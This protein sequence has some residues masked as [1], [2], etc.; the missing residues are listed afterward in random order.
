MHAISKHRRG[1]ATAAAVAT[2]A[3]LISLV[4]LGTGTAAAEPSGAA[5]G[6]VTVPAEFSVD[7]DAAK[8]PLAGATGFLQGASGGQTWVSYADGARVPLPDTASTRFGTG[9]DVIAE[10][11]GA[12]IGLRDP[13]SGTA[14]HLTVPVGQQ[15]RTMLGTSVVT[16]EPN[17]PRRW[18]LLTREADK[19][20]DRMMELPAGAVEVRLGNVRSAYGFMLAYKLDGVAEN[21]WVDATMTPRPLRFG[22]TGGATR[23]AGAQMFRGPVAGRMEVWDLAGDFSA[24]SAAL[25]WA[26]GV[27]V[28]LLG[29]HVLARVPGEAGTERL[30]ARALDGGP[31]RVVLDH[32]VGDVAVGPGGRVVATSTAGGS[33]HTYHSVSVPE[34]GGAPVATRV[35]EAPLARTRVKQVAVAQGVM[36]TLDQ[37]PWNRA[38][39]RAV[40]LGVGTDPSAGPRT[41]RGEDGSLHHGSC[42][43]GGD[44]ENAVPTGDGR[45]VFREAGY[46]SGMYVLQPGGTLPATRVSGVDDVGGD[47]GASGR[48]VLYGST[49]EW[50]VVDL[51]TGAL[52]YRRAHGGRG[53]SLVG[54]S[55]WFP[56]GG[57]SVSAVDVRSGT[58][59]RTAKVA[60]CE[61]KGVE[62]WS[63]FAHWRCDTT[64]G[65]R[66]LATGANVALPGVHPRLGDGYAVSTRGADLLLTPLKGSAP[67]RVL[68]TGVD[69][70]WTVDRF[71]GHVSYVD[72]RDRVHVVPAGVPASA[73][74]V[75]DS[76]RPAEVVDRRAEAPRSWSGKWWLSKPAASWRAEFR[77]RAGEVV[78]TL[79]GGE[80]RGRIDAVWDGKAADG[81]TLADGLYGW[82]LTA[83]PADGVGPALTLTGDVALTRERS[84]ASGTYR[85]VTPTRVMD[86]RGG[87]GA[88]KAKV[89]PGGTVTLQVGG[90]GG[91]PASGVS[92]VVMNV[93]ATNATSST[94]VSVYPAG[95]VRTSASNLNVVAG[96]NVSNL[97]TVP[98]VDGKATFY[99][100]AGSVD[101]LADVAGY[102]SLAGDGSRFAPVKPARILDTRAGLGAPKAE[103]GAGRTVNVQVTGRGGVP[104]SGVSAVVMN[105]TATNPTASSFVSVYPDGTTRTSASN[106][107][108]VAGQTVANLVVVPV[109]NGR[110]SLYNHAGS[111]DLIADVSGY[112]T[113]GGDGS[114]FEPLPP[115]RV[116]DT[117]ENW[118]ALKLAPRSTTVLAIAGL[119]GVPAEG[120]SAVVLNLTATNATAPTFL[121]V[122][123]PS[124]TVPEASHV[125]VVP[126]QTV[127][128]LVVVPV[129]NGQIYIENHAG[130]VD[131]IVDVFGYYAD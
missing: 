97:V 115:E 59:T 4:P 8:V 85:P 93:T 16:V 120:V 17:A 78:R 126:G 106:L 105:V 76:V 37:V 39:V 112:F 109:V 66:D 13:V 87:L 96:R 22:T 107:N 104:A 128:N 43:V 90:R 34:S 45:L 51:D 123:P 118:M 70:R 32:V 31:D 79:T 83:V 80:T 58:V 98:V 68:A 14:T 95:T 54:G 122:Y 130:S 121:T 71:G 62:V 101:L 67:T 10:V 55:L 49:D 64:S 44:C 63:T 131:A 57:G 65:V 119:G 127:P 35:A 111:V 125:N 25:D 30:V 52:V 86:T 2:A 99:N 110:V 56:A 124:G 24:P 26:D 6:T 29:G 81:G 103:V 42:R 12:S 19:V 47:I 27:P 33:G 53:A 92:A 46:G 18:H 129:V 73:L 40:E 117:R 61:V 72:D 3:A 89:G 36:H 15:F 23:V 38:R 84:L 28:A 21:V 9:S 60:D 113:A 108:V 94:Y 91:V 114:L 102:Y 41:D 75:L 50:R 82:T 1:R 69:H 100:R 48:H 20:T 7:P 5:S 74:S 11:F 116:M 77:N 88:P